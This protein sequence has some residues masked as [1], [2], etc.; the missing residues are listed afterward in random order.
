VGN[1]RK[2]AFMSFNKEDVNS[3]VNFVQPGE[4]D[5]DQDAWEYFKKTRVDASVKTLKKIVTCAQMRAAAEAC[6][7]SPSACLD[8]FSRKGKRPCSNPIRIPSGHYVNF[9]RIL[10]LA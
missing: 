5:V 7:D 2:L 4:D 3:R 8:P 10:D 9:L 6:P 1:M